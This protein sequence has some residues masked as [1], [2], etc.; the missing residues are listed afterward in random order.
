MKTTTKLIQKNERLI[1]ES[2]LRKMIWSKKSDNDN[3]IYQ[4]D[5]KKNH[6]QLAR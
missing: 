1:I 4:V 6:R 5:S 3:F 2:D